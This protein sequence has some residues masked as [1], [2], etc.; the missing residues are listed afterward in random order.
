MTDIKLPKCALC[1]CELAED[2][3]TF[4]YLGHSFTIDLPKC[5]QCG[6]VFVDEE[7]VRGRMKKVEILLED[8]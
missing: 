2:K 7:L 6:Q 1:D 8:K 5:P 3:V 4:E